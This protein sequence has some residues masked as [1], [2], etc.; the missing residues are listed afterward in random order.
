M[1]NNLILVLLPSEPNK[2][3]ISQKEEEATV[4]L[5]VSPMIY[6][7]LYC[8]FDYHCDSVSGQREYPL[9]GHTPPSAYHT[10]P[11]LSS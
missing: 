1:N 2:A 9:Q 10:V 5:E 3:P 6:S 8:P 7:V 11:V 4:P